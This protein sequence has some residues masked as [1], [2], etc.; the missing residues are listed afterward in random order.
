[1]PTLIQTTSPSAANL[2]SVCWRSQSNETRKP[3]HW[4][5]SEMQSWGHQASISRWFP[6]SNWLLTLSFH[7]LKMEPPVTSNCPTLTLFRKTTVAQQYP[8]PQGDSLTP[9]KQSIINCN[10]KLITKQLYSNFWPTFINRS[11]TVYPALVVETWLYI[12][13]QYTD[14]DLPHLQPFALSC[15]THT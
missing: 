13:W 6:N 1:M 14:N 9:E 5:K 7:V 4:Q 8:E 2:T 3:H 11:S 10:Y 12:S 15:H